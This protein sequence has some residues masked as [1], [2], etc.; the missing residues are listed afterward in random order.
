MC[1]IFGYIGPQKAVKIALAG[2]KRLEYRGYDSAGIAGLHDGKLCVCKDKGKISNL[3]A[4]VR[5]D[6]LS[7]DLAV[8]HTRWATH[9]E[10]SEINAHPHVDTANTLALVHNGIIENHA[11]LRHDLENK[12]VTFRSETDTEVLAQLI[13]DLYDGDIR[14]AVQQAL[15]MCEGSFAI[16]LVHKDYPGHIIAAGNESPLA[17]GLGNGEVF[18]ASDSNAFLVHTREV[19]YLE[20]SE[21]AVVTADT[22]DVFDA[23]TSKVQKTVELLEREADEMTKDGFEHFMLKEISEQP[24]TIRNALLSRFMEEYGIARL[25]GLGM[26]VNELL[27]VDRILFLACGT[28]WHAAYIAAYMIEEMAR[29]PVQVEI[30]SEFRYKNPIVTDHTLVIAISQSGETADTLAAMRELKSK[31]A[32]ILGLCNVQG[33]TL[34][35]EADHCLYLRAGAEISVC[36]TKSFVSQVVLLALF[37]LLMARIRHMSKNE[38]QAFLKDLVLLPDQVQKVIDNKEEISRLAKKY[39]HYDNFF[40]LGRQHMYPASLEGALKLKEISYINATG[41]PAGEMKHGPI[42]L[43]NEECPTIAMCANKLTY[44]KLLSN[45]REVK[46]RSGPILAIADEDTLGLEDIAEDI[47]RVPKT[48]DN[49]AAINTSVAAQLLAYYIAKERGTEIDQ[50]RNLAKSVTVE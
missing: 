29:I 5:E 41:Y 22:C 46:A 40:F 18:I 34:S 36:A 37:T 19:F 39:A 26:D 20:N 10:P 30:S 48:N 2:I 3:E 31:G 25:D 21:V 4:K 49:L 8:A 13:A 47:I 44:D 16:A 43:I 9:G 23:T 27:A 15:E 28:S 38:G 14:K 1:G 50:P 11:F 35:R 33:S 12:G 24:Q 7:L 45:L 6:N 42:A 32:K 17:V